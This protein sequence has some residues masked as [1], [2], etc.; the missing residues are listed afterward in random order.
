M[1]NITAS[2]YIEVKNGAFKIDGTTVASPTGIK[3]EEHT[4]SRSWND[5]S[6]KQHKVNYRVRRKITWI[7]EV[8]GKE[9]LVYI[10]NILNNKRINTG[11]TRFR[12]N[13]MYIDGEKIMTVEW[14]TPLEVEVIDSKKDLY[15]V[16]ISFVEP[17]GTRLPTC[18]VGEV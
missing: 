11:S 16:Q 14:A 7:Y 2:G 1:E 6:G 13:T 5:A 8:I 18:D 17:E 4:L 10:Y 12:V 3:W 9:S 15:S